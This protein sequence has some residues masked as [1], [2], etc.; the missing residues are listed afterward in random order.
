MIFLSDLL[1]FRPDYNLIWTID[2]GAGQLRKVESGIYKKLINMLKN[3]VMAYPS[4]KMILLKSKTM[5]SKAI[6]SGMPSVISHSES[7]S[8]R[9]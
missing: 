3:M 6:S 5:S 9:L 2:Q 1:S 8:C 4:E 7:S